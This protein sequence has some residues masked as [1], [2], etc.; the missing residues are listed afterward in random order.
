LASPYRILQSDI[1]V[2][3]ARETT[4]APFKRLAKCFGVRTCCRSEPELDL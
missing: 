2:P 3:F 4:I 1:F